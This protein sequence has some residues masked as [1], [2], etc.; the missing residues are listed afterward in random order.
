MDHAPVARRPHA[1]I[2][3]PPAVLSGCYSVFLPGNSAP[4]RWVVCGGPA[5]TLLRW[6]LAEPATQLRTLSTPP[7]GTRLSRH[8]AVA[9]RSFPSASPLRW[10]LVIVF[11]VTLFH[12]DS[13]PSVSLESRALPAATPCGHLLGEL[14][15][16]PLRSLRLYQAPPL[17]AYSF[18]PPRLDEL[19]TSTLPGL[20]GTSYPPLC[21]LASATS[22][23]VPTPSLHLRTVAGALAN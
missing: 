3:A 15:G 18:A 23:L 22:P 5:S 20:I 14:L 4:L 10:A 9:T 2:S 17:L 1:D 19:L 8:A 11:F 16:E 13:G 7:S 6:P 12:R 21:C